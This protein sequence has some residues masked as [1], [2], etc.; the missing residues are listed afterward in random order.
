LAV[1]AATQTLTNKTISGASNTITNVSLTTGV[2]GTLPLA[3]GGTGGTSQS[4]ALTNILPSQTGQ[5]GN[6]LGTNGTSASWVTTLTNPMTTLGDIIYENATPTAARLAGNTTTTKQ[7]LTQ[8]GTGSVSAAPGWATIVASDLPTSSTITWSGAQTFSGGYSGN[9]P[10]VYS[11][12]SWNPVDTAGTTTNAQTGTAKTN[13]VTGLTVT[14]GSSTTV[15]SGTSLTNGTMTF[16]FANV[17]RYQIIANVYCTHGNLY[18]NWLQNFNYSG[19]ATAYYL[20]STFQSVGVPNA[21][22]FSDTDVFYINVTAAN[23]TF[24]VQ[25]TC[26]NSSSGTNTQHTAYA[27]VQVIAL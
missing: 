10:A 5:S 6:V 25:A 21:N 1:L 24:I 15:T 3:N 18:T 23:Q 27:Q 16:T 12:N 4:T 13:G 22:N 2:T 8:T 26:A 17:G 7:F 11:F 9:A 14:T 20:S 19:T